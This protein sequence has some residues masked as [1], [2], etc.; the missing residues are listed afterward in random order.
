ML[1][2]DIFWRYLFSPEL[3]EAARLS[4]LL[5]EVPI[6]ILLALILGSSWSVVITYGCDSC[7][8]SYGFVWATTLL[9][10]YS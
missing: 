6:L 7:E 1:W 9:C 5:I 10:S 2:I 8:L 4:F 3:F